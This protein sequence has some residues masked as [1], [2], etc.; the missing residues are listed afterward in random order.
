[1]GASSFSVAANSSPR[2][3]AR[4]SASTGLWQHTSRS[5]GNSGE[6]ISTRSCSSNSDNCSAP[7]STRALICGA[8]N[9]LIQ[10]SC[11]GRN[12]SLMRALV[13]M[14]RSP[15]R[16]TLLSPNR[17]LILVIWAARV[18]GSA[19]LPSNTS[20]AIGIPAGEHSSP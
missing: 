9:A 6:L 14:P 13:S 5:P 4:S 8:R 16:H 19:V 20:I 3:R 10:S 11:A 2:L 12:S 18:F 7:L 1:M 17:F 15:T